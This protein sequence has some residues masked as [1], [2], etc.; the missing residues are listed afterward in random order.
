MLVLLY[1][2]TIAHPKN[3]LLLCYMNYLNILT[4][5]TINKKIITN[6]SN[7][8]VNKQTDNSMFEFSFFK[9]TLHF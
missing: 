2:Y 5:R 8:N 3:V 1:S 9:H 6:K 7:I 4:T